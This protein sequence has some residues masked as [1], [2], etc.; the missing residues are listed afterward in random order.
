MIVKL[1]SLPPNQHECH[2]SQVHIAS[3]CSCKFTTD[4]IYHVFS[5]P[6][7]FDEHPKLILNIELKWVQRSWVN[8]MVPLQT[9]R[10]HVF[11]RYTKENELLGRWVR[12]RQATPI[13]YG[14]TSFFSFFETEEQQPNAKLKRMRQLTT[15]QAFRQTERRF[16]SQEFE[17]PTSS[18]RFGCLSTIIQQ[19]R[20]IS[21]QM[22]LLLMHSKLLQFTIFV[23]LGLFRHFEAVTNIRTWIKSHRYWRM[24]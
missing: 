8:G 11:P 6:S 21:D 16:H 7:R 19:L 20:V 18:L 17:P 22:I 9:H 24:L 1:A 13:L 4:T 10:E 15:S 14:T 3:Q 23:N 5:L 12:P 2:Q